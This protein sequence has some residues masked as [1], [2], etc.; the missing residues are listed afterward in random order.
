[1]AI[2][3]KDNQVDV[4][5]QLQIELEKYLQKNKWNNP[6]VRTS[7][8]D[9]L[10]TLIIYAKTPST[11]SLLIRY[12]ENGSNL[13]SAEIQKIEIANQK[14]AMEATKDKI[15]KD[16]PMHNTS[17]K[18]E[19]IKKINESSNNE[20]LKKMKMLLDEIQEKCENLTLSNGKNANEYIQITIKKGKV[21]NDS[22][23]ELIVDNQD[24]DIIKEAEEKKEETPKK[25]SFEFPKKDSSPKPKEEPKVEPK[26]TPQPKET[27]PL[28]KPE[29]QVQKDKPQEKPVSKP[30]PKKEEKPKEDE[31]TVDDGN[32]QPMLN[33]YEIFMKNFLVEENSVS[34]KLSNAISKTI[35]SLVDVSANAVD[36]QSSINSQLKTTKTKVSHISGNTEPLNSKNLNVSLKELNNYAVSFKGWSSDLMG[37]FVSNIKDILS[38]TS[39]PKVQRIT[40]KN[41]T[42]IIKNV[43]GK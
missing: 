34:D 20:D 31:N 17:L 43:K 6:K 39:D 21:N 12:L 22:G 30:E 9:A 37:S 41:L 5:D 32:V 10:N 1:M 15:N 33:N 24:K 26:P 23:K 19:S 27:K 7:F 40:L 36:K 18:I 16:G 8:F 14:K 4:S 3:N 38:H 35:Q 11:Q 25:K 42:T 28:V 13:L 2:P 29:L